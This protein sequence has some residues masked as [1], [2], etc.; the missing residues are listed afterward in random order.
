L[1]DAGSWLEELCSI[2]VLNFT[3]SG[4]LTHLPTKRNCSHVGGGLLIFPDPYDPSPQF[5]SL[6]IG[7]SDLLGMVLRRQR[8][9]FFSFLSLLA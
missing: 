3:R 8:R 5:F 4:A 1:C 6:K 7:R 2:L 9:F